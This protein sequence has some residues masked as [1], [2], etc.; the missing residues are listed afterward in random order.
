[1]KRWVLAATT[2]AVG[3]GGG[4]APGWA[5]EEPILRPRPAEMRHLADRH[6]LLDVVNT[7]ERLVAVG[8][9]GHI[10]LSVNGNDWAQS[11]VPV[12]AALTAVDFAEDGLHGWAVGHDAVIL[13]TE[14]GGKTWALQA[15]EPSLER[16]YHDVIALDAQ[17]AIA[18]GAYG[19]LM[20]T[21]DGGATWEEVDAPEIREDEVHFNAIE[22]LGNGALFIAG[23][24]GMLA[25]S[26]DEGETWTRLESP[27][28]S[29]FFG[30]L[31][32]GERGVLVYGLRGTLYAHPDPL[33]SPD[34]E[35]WEQIPN[36]SVATMFGGTR[37]K[38]GRVVLVGLNGTVSFMEGIQLRHFKTAKGTPLSAV[39]EFGDGL[40]AVGESGVQRSAL[41]R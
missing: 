13:R 30:A 33:G 22:R 23:E 39:I 6:L 9:R 29:S 31:A 17:R 24:S 18:V 10:L 41:I 37:L 8:D 11:E 2:A 25:I 1:M 15:F 26:E 3:W 21:E 40:L 5:E 35:G 19:M 28:Q 20:R 27:Y 16:P 4:I 14:D 12:R 7:G 36:D 38:D 34:V 32:D